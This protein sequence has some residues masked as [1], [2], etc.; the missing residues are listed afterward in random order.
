M[1]QSGV[2]RFL[3]T[4]S[5]ALYSA[6]METAKILHSRREAAHLI[7]VSIREIDKL[8]ASGQ[9]QCLR[10]GRRVLISR[11]ALEELFRS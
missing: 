1:P 11:K 6:S 2:V 7:S 3:H 5:H 9:L 8:I 4:I 10:L